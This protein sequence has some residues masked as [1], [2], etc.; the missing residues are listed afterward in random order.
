M[1]IP[2]QPNPGWQLSLAQLSPS[3]SLFFLIVELTFDLTLI[4]LSSFCSI[5]PNLME[6]KIN[7]TATELEFGTTSATACP[8]LLSGLNI[9]LPLV[10]NA[11]TR[12]YLVI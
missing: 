4:S 5:D 11:I 12:F 1:L 9:Y 2:K 6:Q 10:A 8:S 3:L 7:L